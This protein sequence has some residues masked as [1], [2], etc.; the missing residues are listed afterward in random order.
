M[1]A[2]AAKN[3]PLIERFWEKVKKTEH[4]WEWAGSLSP[5]GYGKIYSRYLGKALYAHR[6]SALLVNESIPSGKEVCHRCDNRR[7]VRPEHLFIGTRQENVRDAVNKNR[8]NT[9]VGTDHFR[10]KMDEFSVRLARQLHAAG[11]TYKGLARYFQV[12]PGV[13]RSIVT[14]E[15]YKDVD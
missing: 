12:S 2:R 6:L 4:C 14:G 8:L 3:R 10:S 11:G 13:I 1:N 9:P 15:S 5:Q 7:C